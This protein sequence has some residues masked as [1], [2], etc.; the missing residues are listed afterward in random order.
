MNKSLAKFK[1]SV[2]ITA[3]SA[4]VIS[5]MTPLA[6]S[7]T[8]ASTFATN[9]P[10]STSLSLDATVDMKSTFGLPTNSTLD[11]SMQQVWSEGQGLL[12]TVTSP[13]GWA[14]EYRVGQSWQ[15]SIPADRLQVSGVRAS[16]TALQTGPGTANAPQAVASR[17][18][19]VIVADASS[20]SASGR[21]DGWDVFLSP[22]YIL[23]VYHHDANYKLEC[24]LRATGALC[25]PNAVYQVNGYATSNGS[26]GTYYRGKV[27]SAVTRAG[28]AEM[29]C[30]NV[31]SLPFTSCGS[32]VIGSGSIAAQKVLN[33]PADGQISESGSAMGPVL[34]CSVSM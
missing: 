14:L 24:H 1:V 25:D 13:T 28:N 12:G 27:Y 19:T 26:G 11:A 34:T 23:N 8:V 2:W 4:L 7:G 21:G 29:I 18:S 5:G 16:A 22:Q 3:I 10:T 30:T 20:I 32:T 15:S 31:A 33:A 9:P 6:A 17:T